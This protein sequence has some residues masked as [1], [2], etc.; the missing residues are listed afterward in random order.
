MTPAETQTVTEAAQPL[1]FFI[2]LF[3]CVP[4]TA[5]A[6][7]RFVRWLLSSA[8]LPPPIEDAVPA[9]PWPDW[10]GIALFAGLQ[11][12]MGLIRAAYDSAA[13]SGLIPSEPPGGIPMFSPGIFLAQIVPPLIGLVALLIFSRRGLASIGVRTGRLLAG[14]GYGVF[15]FLAVMPVCAIALLVNY[16]L[17][18]LVGLPVQEHPLTAAVQIH[19]EAWVF[20]LAVFQ[21]GVLAAVCEEFAFRG[22]LMMSLL[23]PSA[24]CGPWS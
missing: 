24:R 23:R 2:F 17:N 21:A 10:A 14:I 3:A 13:K 7:W 18:R 8:P 20:L 1:W 16:H 5:V 9:V 11:I 15:A 4:F 19:R 12:G 6:A 22:I